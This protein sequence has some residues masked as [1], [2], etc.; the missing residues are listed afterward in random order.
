MIVYV[1]TCLYVKSLSNKNMFKLNLLFDKSPFNP[2]YPKSVPNP[3]ILIIFPPKSDKILMLDKFSFFKFFLP[4]LV[5]QTF[6]LENFSYLIAIKCFSFDI[7][8]SMM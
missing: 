7:V 1:F 2:Y 5:G 4:L 8:I 3:G 6:D